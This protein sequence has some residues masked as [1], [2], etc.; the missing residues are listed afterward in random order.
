MKALRLAV[1]AFSFLFAQAATAAEAPSAAPAAVPGAAV[2]AAVPG[3]AMQGAP[4]YAPD[5]K[6]F[7]YVNTEAPKGGELRLAAEGTFDT[8]NPFVLKGVSAPGSD[9]IYQTLMENSSDEA[10][11]EYGSIAATMQTPE[12]RSWVVFELRPEAK[13]DDGQ[14]IT[15]EDVVW[16]FNTLI[17]KGEPHF[18]AYYANVKKAEAENPHRVKFTFSI[19]GNRE[20]PL[21]MGQLA[22]L[23]K[24]YWEGKTFDTLTLE[25]PVG[26][27]PYRIKTV[28]AGQHIVLERCKDWWAKD[29]PINRGRYNFD[30]ISFDMYRDPTVMFQALFSGQYDFRAENIAKAWATEYKQKPVEQGLI[31]KEE[32]PNSVPVGMQAFVFNTRK[33][34]FADAKTR[35]ALAYAFDFEW[36]NKEVAFSAYTRTHSYFD[37]SELASSG[38]PQGRE[39]EILN[40]FRGKVPDE[41]FTKPFVVPSTDG[42]GNARDN[43]TRAREL[44]KEAGWKPGAG[45]K[46]ER[47][48]KPLAFEFLADS[49]VFDRWIAPFVLNLKKLGVDVQRRVVDNAQYI[50]RLQ[51]FDFDMIVHT[52]GE[53]LSPG[54]EQRGFWGSERADQKGS[55]NVIGVKNPVV[56]DLVKQLV[57]AKDREELIAVTHALDRVLLWNYYVIPNWHISAWRVAYWDKF[58]RPKVTAKYSLSVVDTW[59][60]DPAKAAKISGKA[61][62]GK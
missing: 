62:S 59:W 52:F 61:D 40:A 51:D 33:P 22:V 57:V 21:I 10:F 44:L 39:L 55:P 45:G 46:L 38:L 6:N 31:K 36:S 37:N 54:N 56:D 19:A 15:A 24:H 25:P 50:K 18:R 28:R 60:Y 4:K 23:P 42:S 20:L 14:P 2:P 9:M 8:L 29:L 27:G 16:T 12:D 7:D 30:T 35:E 47:D 13:W 11:S 58:D 48:G 3:M 1:L 17:E 43:L 53:S 41:L 26:S 49:E 34:V 5:F 32:I